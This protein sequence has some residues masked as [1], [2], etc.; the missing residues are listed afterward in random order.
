[1][2]R[3]LAGKVVWV[4]GAS[5]G[6]GE[7]LAVAAAQSGAYLILTARRAPEL[8]RVRARCPDPSCV[9]V[10]PA[11]LTDF[12]PAALAAAA[13]EPFGPVD[14]LVN[15]AGWSQ[16]G[17]FDETRLEVY[18]QVMELDFFAPLAL[19]QAV[20]PA[21]RQRGSGQ[22]VMIGSVLSRIG[23]PMRTGYAAAKH[24]LAGFTQALEAEL[25]SEGIQVTLVMPGY[26][27]TNVSMNALGPDGLPHA[28]LDQSIAKGLPPEVCA[29]AIWKGVARQAPEITIGKERFALLAQ[30]WLPGLVRRVLRR[31]RPQ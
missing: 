15:N 31:Y 14:I 7:A 6:I 5:S 16:R 22:V 4:T 23:T 26:I 19:T 28:R 17:R 3:E 20:L 9:R 10:L 29:A 27:K 18:R 13:S 24:A 30:R 12:D 2:A 21:M 11:D 25:W 1:M 8:E